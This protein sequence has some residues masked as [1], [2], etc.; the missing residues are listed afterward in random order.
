MWPREGL[1]ADSV[2]VAERAEGRWEE[3]QERAGTQEG[4]GCG[5][6]LELSTLPLLRP[7]TRCPGRM[8][9]EPS[10]QALG[11][12]ERTRVGGQAKVNW[13]EQRGC[14]CPVK[15]RSPGTC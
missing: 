3:V 12:R 5:Y 9:K 1:L 11:E 14:S 8:R 10:P 7:S 2:P 4:G 6:G 13:P 15:P